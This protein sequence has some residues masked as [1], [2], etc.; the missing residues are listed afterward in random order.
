MKMLIWCCHKVFL[1]PSSSHPIPPHTTILAN[2]K[3]KEN[4]L[5]FPFVWLKHS[6]T[7]CGRLIFCSKGTLM[8]ADDMRPLSPHLSN[9][10]RALPDIFI[11]PSS[12]R[13][14]LSAQLIYTGQ[15]GRTWGWYLNDRWGMVNT[16]LRFLYWNMFYNVSRIFHRN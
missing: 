10:G 8:V 3:A 12:P 1:L 7:E 14:W 11:L 13:P 4:F 16:Y 15:I 2:E 5:R 6:N 9:C